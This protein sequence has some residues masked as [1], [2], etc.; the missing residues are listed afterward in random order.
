MCPYY[1]DGDLSQAEARLGDTRSACCA[2]FKDREEAE[3]PRSAVPLS[4]SAAGGGAGLSKLDSMRARSARYARQPRQLLVDV[5]SGRSSCRRPA[6]PGG[7]EAVARKERRPSVTDAR[8]A[9]GGRVGR[10]GR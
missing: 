9:G 2:V 6:A 3:R 7:G 4:G 5:S 8:T 10:D 1:L